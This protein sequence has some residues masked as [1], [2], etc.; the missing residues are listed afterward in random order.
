HS[1]E[2]PLRVGE[3]LVLALGGRFASRSVEGRVPEAGVSP[4]ER[5]GQLNVGGV[6]GHYRR[7]WP[8]APTP[9][10]R[11]LGGVD[12]GG[13]PLNLRSLR[14][15]EPSP[16]LGGELPPWALVVGSDMEVGKTT[17]ASL[18]AAGLREAGI[19]PTFL[20][21]TGTGRMRDLFRVQHGREEGALRHRE[22]FDFVDAGFPSTCGLDRGDT[23]SLCKGLLRF[24]ARGSD[25]LIVELADSPFDDASRWVLEDEELRGYLAR[26]GVILFAC[27][28]LGAAP[29]VEWLRLRYR[30]EAREL[31]LTGPVA[32]TPSW[33]KK[34]SRLTACPP[35]ASLPAQLAG[36]EQARASAR[37]LAAAALKVLR[38]KGALEASLSGA[39]P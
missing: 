21:V 1:R 18:L 38:C 26:R 24:G 9:L 37:E 15:V 22:G 2:V 39:T 16:R 6:A 35:V 23:W 32:N 10:L 14:L 7:A 8:Q 36:A 3:T 11:V 19:A 12:G 17:A 31:I 5:I 13:A 29:L 33:R 30:L 34:A 25:F 4:G 28:S 27:E 20:K